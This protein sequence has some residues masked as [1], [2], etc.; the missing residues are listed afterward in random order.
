MV[1]FWTILD[2]E[3]LA[4]LTEEERYS[5][6]QKLLKESKLY[7]DFLLEK[8]AKSEAMRTEE[9][10]PKKGPK[11]RKYNAGSSPL[12][13]VKKSKLAK[14]TWNGQDIH[15]DQPLLISGG[16][17]R[18][19][20]IEGT[21]FGLSKFNFISKLTWFW[22]KIDSAL[23]LVKIRSKLINDWLDVDCKNWL[24]ITQKWQSGVK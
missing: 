12:K 22:L 1:Y 17:M 13:N 23:S 18:N 2:E 8:M 21:F 20:Q 11:K 9:K 15:E 14:R 5:K 3:Q 10:A 6:L 24:K 16:V 19:Y 4:E 7:S